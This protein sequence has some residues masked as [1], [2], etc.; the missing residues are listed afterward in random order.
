MKC[1]ARPKSAANGGVEAG[2]GLIRAPHNRYTLASACSKSAIRSSGSSNPIEMR[3]RLSVIPRARSEEH[4]SELQSLMRNS[5]ARF[6]LKK[7]KTTHMKYQK[8]L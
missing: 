1:C 7:K 4:T 5:Y 2:R 6:L 3:T 8:Q